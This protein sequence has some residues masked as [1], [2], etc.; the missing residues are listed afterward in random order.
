VNVGAGDINGDGDDDVITGTGYG[1]LALV[2][3][4]DGQSGQLRRNFFAF[5]STFLGG[6]VV[7]AG[8]LEGDGHADI[9]VGV[10]YGAAGNVRVFSGADGSLRG[11]FV[12]Q[13]LRGVTLTTMDFDGDGKADI[14]AS[15][16]FSM[17]RE[18]GVVYKGT[19][20]T[21]LASWGDFSDDGLGADEFSGAFIAGWSGP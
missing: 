12:T 6:V 3:V 14:L 16:Q 8:D 17:N 4:F 5:S 7:S 21:G 11:E 19:T 15:H 10:D 18:G 13:Y 1:G 20:L 9:V 2:N